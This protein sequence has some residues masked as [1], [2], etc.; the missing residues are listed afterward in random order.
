MAG[1]N[2]KLDMA[3]EAQLADFMD[4]YFY[5]KSEAK[6]KNTP[7]WVSYK[8]IYD[9]TLQKQGVDVIAT[10]ARGRFCIDEKAA[11][12]YSNAMIPTFAFELDSLQGD[13]ND[14]LT[15]GWFVNDDL[16]T[17]Y[18]MLIWSNVKCKKVKDKDN[19]KSV[20]W[21]RADVQ[22]ILKHD[23]TILEAMLISKVRLRKALED[24]FHLDKV[25]LLKYAHELRDPKDKTGNIIYLNNSVKVQFSDQLKEQPVN[26]VVQK[27][28]LKQYAQAM[29]Y[30][31]EDGFARIQ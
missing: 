19:D 16:K 22:H 7:D 12:Y 1:S 25:R 26:A 24:N 28:F 30:I 13:D 5:K 9:E 18:Y 20:I 29:Y 27:N 6:R 4:A 31:G 14:V 10:T 21:V 15:D 8:R 23:F 17:Q 11:I 3:S 2:R